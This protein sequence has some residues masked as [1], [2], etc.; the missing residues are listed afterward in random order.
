[1]A[2]HPAGMPTYGNAECR[3]REEAWS[4]CGNAGPYDP[5]PEACCA[6]RSVNY[7]RRS[8]HPYGGPRIIE[9]AAMVSRM[10]LLTP[11]TTGIRFAS[12]AAPAGVGASCER[13]PARATP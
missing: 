3:A 12:M 4:G 10:G 8:K 6:A 7:L 11:A 1:M 5:P 9:V 13:K 2:T